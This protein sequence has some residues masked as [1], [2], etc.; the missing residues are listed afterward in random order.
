VPKETIVVK[1]KSGNAIL[2]VEDEAEIR[3]FACKVLHLEGYCCLEAANEQEAL[4]L[5]ETESIDLVFLDLKLNDYN[6]WEILEKIKMNPKTEAIPVIVCT[7]SFGQPQ[8]QRALDMGAV[9]YLV[10]PLSANDL[11]TT[12]SRFLT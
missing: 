3:H 4:K 1:R 6:G 8:E 12:V 9:G 5:L 2:C 7:A 11:R 10:K